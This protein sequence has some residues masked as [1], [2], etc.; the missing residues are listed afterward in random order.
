MVLRD[1]FKGNGTLPDAVRIVV[2]SAHYPP[3][4]V[5]G[6][7]LQPQRLARGLRGRGHDVSVYAGWLGPR[8][9]LEA[10]TALDETGLAVRWLVTTPWIGWSDDRNWDNPPVTADF[11]AWLAT[12]RPDVVHLHSLQSLGAGLVPAARDS[13]ARVVVTMHDFWWCCA[14]QFLVDP[15]LTPCSVVVDAGLCACEV[16]HAWLLRRNAALRER[17]AAADLVLCPSTSAAAVMAANGIDPHRLRVDENGL[18]P[19]PPSASS[20][21]AASPGQ[22]LERRNDRGGG[23]EGDVRFVYAGGPNPL[24][25]VQVVLGAATMLAADGVTGWE[26]TAYGAEEHAPRRG[27]GRASPGPVTF[28]PAFDPAGTDAVLADTD[29]IVIPS[30]MR[31]SH[32]LLTREALGRGVPVVVTDSI[33]PEEVVVDGVNGLVVPTGDESAL[34][35]AMRRLV[36]E[37]GLL[38]S[39]R[40]AS[41]SRPVTI[42]ALA[43][44]V[45]GLEAVFAD[46]VDPDPV[47]PAGPADLPADFPADLP[48]HP[49][50][51]PVDLIDPVDPADPVDPV[52]P[53]GPA[54]AGRVQRVVF[55]VGITG[56]PL[57]YRA[58]LPAEALGLLGVRCDVRPYRHHDLPELIDAADVVCVY[59]VPATVAVLAMIDRARD[60]GTPVLFDVDD[61]IFDP[62]LAAEIPALTILGPAE[63]ELWLEGVRRYRTTMEHCD[64]YVGSTA[65]LVEHAAAVTGLPTA[66]FDNGVGLLLARRSDQAL[67]ARARQR[68]ARSARSPGAEPA[69]VVIG[70]LSGTTTHDHDWAFVEPAVVDVLDRHPGTRLVLGGYLVESPGLARFGERVVRHGFAPWYELP[71]LLADIDVNLA[72]LSPGSRFNEAKSAIKWL[73]AALVETPTIASPTAPFCEA[74]HH[75]ANGMLAGSVPEWTAALDALVGETDRRRRL[76]ARARRDALLRW[77]PH[78]QGRRYLAILEEAFE[79]RERPRPRPLMAWTPVVH[80]EPPEPGELEP[81]ADTAIATSPAGAVAHPP[82]ADRAPTRAGRLRRSLRERGLV[83]TVR[84][85]MA[86]VSSRAV[87]AIGTTRTEPRRA[88]PGKGSALPPPGA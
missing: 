66:R 51:D 36:T 53:A 65:G 72:P 28:A 58:H 83:G 74:I 20:R 32:S 17:L 88:R 84:A 42:R 23:G 49:D 22:P 18:P 19:H 12:V 87:R 85:V 68:R 81:Y 26:L 45:K 40:A 9:P 13:G 63:A 82:N 44:Q 1:P 35:T 39:L 48:A 70:Y 79:W 67:Q 62:D 41:R 10:W 5:S 8:E 80:D 75:G 77:S 56:A 16:D 11:A 57:R 64:G 4:F 27:V 50:P 24:K 86:K 71:S 25:G 43:D 37:P 15:T 21:P 7:T 54:G 55:M 76:G 31:E 14:R 38:G 3:N 34:A 69:P 60:R 78:L 33:G 52:D 46:L 2:V 73:E 6:G 47:D 30:V 29:V 59:R 61:L